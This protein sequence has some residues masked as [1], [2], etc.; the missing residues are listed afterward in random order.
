[1]PYIYQSPFGFFLGL[2]TKTDY[3]NGFDLIPVEVAKCQVMVLNFT[4]NPM[5]KRL[6]IG[7]AG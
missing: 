2:F 4:L 5:L 7:M 6:S 1:M 3:F